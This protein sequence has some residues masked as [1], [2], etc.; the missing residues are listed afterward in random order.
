M[1]S[2]PAERRPVTIRIWN[3]CRVNMVMTVGDTG[4]TTSGAV[5]GAE[6]STSIDI[7]LDPWAGL[8]VDNRAT[9]P[10]PVNIRE[11]ME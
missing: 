11:R 4:S 10:A 8:V 9:Y 2:T 1:S 7:E 3:G 6:C 5:G